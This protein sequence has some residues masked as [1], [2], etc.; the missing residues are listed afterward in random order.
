[1][2]TT[3]ASAQI[4][5]HIKKHMFP[6]W[7]QV[8]DYPDLLNDSGVRSEV[9]RITDIDPQG[10]YSNSMERWYDF[11][12][13]KQASLLDDFTSTKKTILVKC[14]I[15]GTM[16]EWHTSA[17]YNAGDLISPAQYFELER[18]HWMSALG[19]EN[20][21]T[22]STGKKFIHNVLARRCRLIQFT[23]GAKVKQTKPKQVKV[24]AVALRKAKKCLPLFIDTHLSKVK[25]IEAQHK[26]QAESV[27][28]L[29]ALMCMDA[30]IGDWGSR[31]QSNGNKWFHA[32]REALKPVLAKKKQGKRISA[33]K[34]QKWVKINAQRKRVRYMEKSLQ[35][36]RNVKKSV[37]CSW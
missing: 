37:E 21:G 7:K 32:N 26:A 3:R 35:T 25:S 14:L 8:M 27:D 12:K 13:P 9:M 1:M 31:R 23:K 22:I 19:N 24:G 17:E 36:T 2:S 30:E 10:H 5:R 6:L 20:K 34:K 29:N 16:S 11:T 18:A 28:H 33:L 4:N 15:K